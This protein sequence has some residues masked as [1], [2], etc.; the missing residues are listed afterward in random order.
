[1]KLTLFLHEI[2]RNKVSLIV[3]SVVLAWMLGI[4][5]VIYP[6]MQSQMGDLSDM[7]ADMGAFSDAFGMDQ[8]QFGEFMGYFGI[9]CGNTLGLGGALLAAIVGISALSKE[10][11]DKTAELLLTLPVSRSRVVTEKLLFSVLHILVVNVAVF[12]V[13]VLGSV[14]ISA[15]A[16]Y[17]QMALILL[18]YLLMQLEIMA[19]T[20][21]IS[22]LLKR[23]GFGIGIGIGFG[24]YF[25]NILA[26]LTEQIE[27]LKYLTPFGFADSGHIIS[28][29]GLEPISLIIGIILSALGILLAYYQYNRKDIA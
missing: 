1:M 4:C 2:K 28:E 8:L 16:N 19:I 3:W 26:N 14:A 9:E 24:F 23:S 6:E 17:G 21:G 13:C 27:F 5:I 15:D 7:F 11:R 18:S 12:L 10:E 25:M 22:S 20:F 29:G